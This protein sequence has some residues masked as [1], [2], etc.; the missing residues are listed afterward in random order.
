MNL[1][2]QAKKEWKLIPMVFDAALE[3]RLFRSIK[4]SKAISNLLLGLPKGF[5]EGV[6]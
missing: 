6:L 4:L 2:I 5:C 3:I 1:F